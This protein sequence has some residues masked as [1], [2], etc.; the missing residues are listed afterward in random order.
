MNHLKSISTT[1][2]YC[3]FGV[4]GYTQSA[5]SNLGFEQNDFSNWNGYWGNFWNP[6]M[7]LSIIPGRHTI[8]TGGIDPYSCGGLSCVPPGSSYSARLGN[9]NVNA[10]GEK[11]IYSMSVSSLNSIFV[12]KYAALLEDAGHPASDQPK[13][14]VEVK[15]QSGNQIGGSCGIF[16]VYAGQP[17]QNFKTCGGVK[18]LDWSTAAMDLSAFIGQ[19]I[20]IEFTTRDCSQG[21]HFGYAYIW[22]TCMPQNQS[23]AYCKGQ[24]VTLQAPSGFQTYKW[25]EG[26][27]SQN[28][29]ISNP[30]NGNSY[31]V[32]LGSVGNQ[33]ACAVDFT[34]TLSETIPVAT[35]EAKDG[36]VNS[37]ITINDKSQTNNDVISSW[38]WNFGDGSSSTDQNP[39][40]NFLNP[41]TFTVQLDVKTS[42]GCPASSSTQIVVSPAPDVNFS[43]TND[44]FYKPF[45]LTDKTTGSVASLAWDLG[46]GTSSTASSVTHNFLNP[47]KYSVQLIASSPEGCKDTL[48]QSVFAYPKPKADFTIT[49]ACLN[50]SSKFQDVSTLNPISNDLVKS[51]QYLFGDGNSSTL[52]NPIHTYA[53]ERTYQVKLISTSNYGCVDTAVKLASVYPLPNVSFNALP[54]CEGSTTVFTNQSTISNQY[55]Q[56]TL[57]SFEWNI[58]GLWQ[59]NQESTSYMFPKEGLHPTVLK[60]TS[61]HGC[62]D[63]IVKNA[64]IHPLPEVSFTAT[65]SCESFA[66]SFNDQSKVSTT[67]TNNSISAWKYR[68]GDGNESTLQNPTHIFPKEGVYAASLIVTTNNGCKDSST[69]SVDVYPLPNVSF[70]ASKECQGI[71]TIFE[72]QTTISSAHTANTLTVWS[73]HFGD[74]DS[75]VSSL[76]NPTNIFQKEG[77]YKTLLT[78]TSNH[79]CKDS[80]LDTVYVYPKPV[81]N[82][83]VDP[84]CENV[85]SVFKDTSFVSNAYTPNQL[86]SYQ[87]NFGDGKTS[88]LQSPVYMYASDGLYNAVLKVSTNHGCTDSLLKQVRIFPKP[89]ASFSGINLIGCSPICSEI[90][91]TSTVSSPSVISSTNWT[92]SDGINEKDA[93]IYRCFENNTGSTNYYGLSL[94][95]TTSHGCMDTTDSITYFQIYHKPTALFDYEPKE[96]D[97]L[98]TGL[99]FINLSQNATTY[100]WNF[101]EKESSN[102]FEPSIELPSSAGKYDVKLI[103]KTTE[104]CLDS[105]IIT[106]PVKDVLIF[107][108]PNTFTPDHNEF[109][110]IF[111]PVFHS[112]FDPESYKMLIF[113]RWGEIIFESNDSSVGWDGTYNNVLVSDGVYTWKISFKHSETDQRQTAVGHVTLLR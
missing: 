99:T 12:Y 9:A 16:D 58:N 55:T 30:T 59:D 21:G 69:T 111:K 57:T 44:C 103:S 64:I 102:L 32:V 101:Y 36:C 107:Y 65:G 81:V 50:N 63:S 48:T 72:D 76:Q 22:A 110:E 89:E 61:N 92:F 1:F 96:L 88:S 56:N 26:Q 83:N 74:L 86:T 87:W 3:L 109:N 13:L 71:E 39:T 54:V 28:V 23:I 29:T 51:W 70:N 38:N 79:N 104:G 47:G 85:S 43:F 42:N 67:Q 52:Q 25:S 84:V 45:L 78:V 11:L 113:N 10:E 75:S 19:S 100:E 20:Q 27:T 49:D 17:G 5:C 7:G 91:S 14:T 4:F 41:G 94:I 46:D 35:I 106:I 60:V 105:M 15:N 80:I 95:V 90:T 82:F 6:A 40:H 97:I 8:M 73:W 77:V 31:V 98:H 33:G 37:P 93:F 2:I 112:G 53:N 24:P 66:N 18:W 108:V 68:F 34:Y 62:I